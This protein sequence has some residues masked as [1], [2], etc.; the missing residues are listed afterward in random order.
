MPRRDQTEGAVRSGGVRPA[1]ALR[2]SL[3]R[4]YRFGDLRSD[5]MAGIVVG[6]VALPLSMA[7]AIASGVQPQFGLYTAIIAGG[8]IALLGGSMRQISGPT[9]A[10]VV[11]LAPVTKEFGPG[12]LMLASLMAGL[13]LMAMGLARFGRL[14]EFIP[15]PVTTGFTAGIAVVIA[16]LQIKDF[17]GLEMG[18]Q[19]DHFIERI[20]AL[21][22]SL[23]TV[24]A[25]DIIVG[26]VTLS[27]LLVLPRVLRRVPAPLIALPVA[28]LLAWLLQNHAG[29]SVNTI[30]SRFGGVPQVLPA[31]DW[32]WQRP[33]VDGHPLVLSFSLI[34]ELLGPAFAIAMLGAIESLLS[35]V[36]SDGMTGDV[37]DPDTELFAQGAGNVIA[38]FF[39]GFAATGAIARTATNIRNGGRSP[40]AALTHS[41]FILVAILSLARL[42]GYLPMAGLAA[43][44]LIVAKNMAEVEH[45]IHTLRVAPRGDIFVLLLCIT[46]TIVFDMVVSVSAGVVL[47][48][49][50]FMGRMAD[51]AQA[52]RVL[53]GQS[54][55]NVVLPRGV[56]MYRIAGPLFF[57][58]AQKAASALR[59]IGDGVRVVILD[60]SAVPMMDATGLVSLE[61]MLQRLHAQRIYVVIAGAQ[62]QPLQL[63]AKAGWKHRDWLTIYRSFDQAVSLARML[64]ESDIEPHD[65]A[66]PQAPR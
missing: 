44:L 38:P 3:R 43:L 20:G 11:L 45:V 33:G 15:Y 4:G 13:I 41:L 10:F 1:I 6:V 29:M 8:L 46:L 62:E 18:P 42:L 19:P 56:L 50:L 37:H 65:V 14:I 53:D 30:Q 40:I 66:A 31:L 25:G 34:R 59:S 21:Y 54:H 7:L 60:V 48:A 39:G 9:A 2:Q 16:S 32:P 17:L 52:Q 58:A 23:G 36:V 55:M 64:A 27:L 5:V 35:A 47:A 26:G 63:M 22:G 12:G 51:L 57:G 28:A 24:H 61:S 49:L